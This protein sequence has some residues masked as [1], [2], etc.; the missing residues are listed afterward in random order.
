[1]VF[2]VE[3]DD[4]HPRGRSNA[5]VTDEQGDC[6]RKGKRVIGGASSGV[7]GMST[8]TEN[9]V[10]MVTQNGRHVKLKGDIESPGAM[11]SLMEMVL[12][13]IIALVVSRV[14]V[15]PV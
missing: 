10:E 6:H 4:A 9:T 11:V 13:V 3:E 5:I 14:E 15:R 7:D 1:M 8:M 12:V 2:E